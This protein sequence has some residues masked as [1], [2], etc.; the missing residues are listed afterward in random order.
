MGR[1]GATS[2]SR[3][4]LLRRRRRPSRILPAPKRFDAVEQLEI[5]VKDCTED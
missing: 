5:G 2:T 1:L 3:A 4:G